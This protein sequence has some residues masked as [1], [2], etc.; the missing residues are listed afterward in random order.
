MNKILKI[1]FLSLVANIFLISENW[2]SPVE[3]QLP[4]DWYQSPEDRPANSLPSGAIEPQ[5]LFETIGDK[6]FGNF[7]TRIYD[8]H[9]D[10]LEQVS[11]GSGH[12]P[13]SGSLEPGQKEINKN[14]YPPNYSPWHLEAFTTELAVF[15]KGLVGVLTLKGQPAVQVFWRR[16]GP[17]PSSQKQVQNFFEIESQDPKDLIGSKNADPNQPLTLIQSFEEGSANLALA[18]EI[19]PMI[20][21][22]LATG[23]ILNEGEFRRQI[24]RAAEE[25][26]Y[27]ASGLNPTSDNQWWLAFFRFDFMV[28]ASGKVLPA[29]V[30]TT[31]GDLRL[32]FDW[33]RM[34]K[35]SAAPN[36]EPKKPQGASLLAQDL[37]KF[38]RD[39]QEF[40]MGMESD[41]EYAL[42]KESATA[43][44]KAF[45]FRIAL[46]ITA[47]GNIGAIKGNAGA[48]G[49]LMFLNQTPMPVVHPIK[50]K[51]ADTNGANENLKPLTVIEYNSSSN[52][53]EFAT[54]NNIPFKVNKEKE[55]QFQVDRKKFR[56]GLMRA[57]KMGQ[58]FAR[59]GEKVE[60]KKWKLFLLRTSFDLSL[61]GGL[62]LVTLGGTASAEMS[63]FN[64]NF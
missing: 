12:G 8:A 5:G 10:A 31:G 3:N 59:K 13:G 36:P 26:R 54:L 17:K 56:K 49:H 4:D 63:F 55:A 30:L 40:T 22:A 62:D 2:A 32:R 60:A 64:M 51:V 38:R 15:A 45:G 39:L 34:K 57:V 1:L 6:L 44:M 28:G 48:F 35:V 14:K 43:H 47:E 61:S 29:P 11:L 52:H 58:F 9:L 37:D 18:Q 7:L 27:V 25:F 24:T 23:K 16:Q 42:A 46:G 21:S 50:P 33:H 20:K 19:E 41:L 53:Q